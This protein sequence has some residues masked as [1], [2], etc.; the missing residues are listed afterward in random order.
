MFI[1]EKR[2]KREKRKESPHETTYCAQES[3][4]TQNWTTTKLFSTY[5]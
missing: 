5:E 3:I 4:A 2:F 1:K